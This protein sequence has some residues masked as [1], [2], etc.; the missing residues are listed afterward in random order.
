MTMTFEQVIEKLRAKRSGKDWKAKC[1]AHEDKRPSLSIRRGT[2]KTLL[3][4]FAQCTEDAICAAL[5]ITVCDLFYEG[6]RTGKKPAGKIVKIVA[7]YDYSDAN[8]NLLYQKVRMEP[9][10]FT[11]RRPDGKGGWINNLDGVERVLY[12]LSEIIPSQTVLVTE[13]E[14]DAETGVKLGFCT[15]TGGS[16]SDK[17][18]SSFTKALQGKDVV[19]IDDADEGGREKGRAIATALYGAAKSLRLVEMPGAKDLTEWVEKGGTREKLF[20]F[21]NSMPEWDATVDAAG[22]VHDIKIFLS[23]YIILPQMILL[24]L[25][26]WVLHTYVYRCFDALPYLVITSPTKRCGKTKLL[27]CLELICSNPRRASNISEAAL[28]RSIDKFG[29][30]LLLDEA[31]TLRGKGDRSEYMRQILNAGNRHG[32]VVT[33]CVGE[34]KSQDVQDF[35]VFCP[36]VLACIGDA[37]DT[38]MD[39]SVIITMQRKKKEESVSKF[40]YRRAQPKALAIRKRI[41]QFAATQL[42]EI[43]KVTAIELNFLE[44]REEEAWAP[45][46]TIL[47]VAD[48]TRMDELRECALHLSG[49]KHSRDED[50]NLS[51]RLLHDLREIWPKAEPVAFTRTLLERLKGIEESAWANEVEMTPR[52]LSR[53]LR[54]F[55]FSSPQ[56]VRIG[57]ETAMGYHRTEAQEAFTRYLVESNTS[58]TKQEKAAD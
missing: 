49:K 26:V 31:E 57:G 13:G 21:L 39:R 53:M 45:L 48:P 55:G 51:L 25:A 42:A 1:P 41:E 37:P 3:K 2:K 27:E 33:R 5:K 19:V 8:G 43:D 17:W 11:F 10:A 28:F 18:E 40:H 9:K 52:K 16:A 36:K 32:A 15:T 38:I 24:P 23:S 46:F 47:M 35:C 56:S 34:G 12:R 6:R 44:D 20:S 22:L 30:T 54:G 14:K 4:C 58:N 29:P 50:D 7:T